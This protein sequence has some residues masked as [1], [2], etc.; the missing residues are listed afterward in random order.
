MREYGLC[1]D[2]EAEVEKLKE[3]I[4][5]QWNWNYGA[6]P[7]YNIRKSLRIEGCGKFEILLDVEKEGIVKKI[8]FYGDFF[9]NDDPAL[10]AEI[11]EGRH[12]EYGELAERIKDVDISRYFH[13]LDTKTFLALLFE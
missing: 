2:E 7:P 13:N 3:K 8:V 6:S 9:G 12:F 4:Y 10:L 1:A 5:S 11:I